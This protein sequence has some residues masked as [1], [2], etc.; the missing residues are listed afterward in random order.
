MCHLHQEE[1]STNDDKPAQ[2]ISMIIESIHVS[3]YHSMNFRYTASG[4]YLSTTPEASQGI[5]LNLHKH[6]Q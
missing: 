1:T 5:Y 4:E 3:Q 6:H 2:T